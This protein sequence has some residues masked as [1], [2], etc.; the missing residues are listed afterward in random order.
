VKNLLVLCIVLLA[1]STAAI[2]QTKNATEKPLEARIIALDTQGWE[3]WKKNDP[4]WFKENTTEGFI[5][6]SSDGI[7]NKAE[8][9]KSTPTDCKVTAYSLADFKFVMLDKNAV[10]LTYTAKQDAVCG[11]K[12]APST[13]RVAVNYVQRDGKWLEALYMQAP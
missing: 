7:S 10:L 8:V 5:S 9:V 13:L 12:K 3:A 4:T 2:G 6:I 1:P 11:G